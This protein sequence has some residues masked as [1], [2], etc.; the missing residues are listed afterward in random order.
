MSQVSAAVSTDDKARG[1]FAPLAIPT[2]ILW[3]RALGACLLFSLSGLSLVASPAL[4]AGPSVFQQ[5]PPDPA[6]VDLAL[7]GFAVHCDG[8]GD[9]APALQAAIDAVAARPSRR[10]LVFVGPG[11][12]RL[13]ATV[14]VWRGVR[15][16][17][18][19]PQRPVF[20]LGPATPGFQGPDSGYLF[21]FAG[22]SPKDGQPVRDGGASGFF[23]A[24]TNCDIEIADGNPGA[25]GVRF[26]VAQHC[27]LS[28]IDFR[29]G[30]ARAGVERVGNFF[31]NLTFSGGEYGL[32]AHRTAPSWPFL[33]LDSTFTG[34][35][36]AA[37][38]TEEAGM[39]IVRGHFHDL[40]RAIEVEA[41]LPEQLW[42]KDSRFERITG[43]AITLS[44]TAN[45][46]SQGNLQNIVCHDVPTLLTL[47][48]T[49]ESTLAP[50]AARSY[51]VND[52]IHG[53]QSPG[54][55]GV[56]EVKTTA[57]LTPLSAPAAPPATDIPA[58]PP[59]AEWVDART[60]GVRGDGSTDD[61]AALQH[62]LQTHRVLYLP[63]GQYRVSDTLRLRPDGVLIGLHPATTQLALLPGAPAFAQDAGPRPVL[64]TARGGAAIV[65]GIGINTH[66]TPRVIGLDWQA[67]A[68]SL[69]DDVNFTSSHSTRGE[70]APFDWD[71][72][73][74]T[75]SP[76]LWVREGG[77][78]TF[79]GI[80]TANTQARSGLRIT[81]TR[82]SGRVYALSAE[83]HVLR[84]IE[85]E[86]A[87]HWS[88][89]GVQTESEGAEGPNDL[90]IE[91][92]DGRDLLFANTFLYRVSRTHTPF[93]NAIL[94]TLCDRVD[95][96]GLLVF[97]PTKYA[98][99]AAVHDT[100]TGRRENG[101]HWASL[102]V[103]AL[104]APA[105]KLP[106]FATLTTL[107]EG[108][109]SIDGL[110]PLP[111]GELAFI[112]V[113]RGQVFQW[114]PATGLR[115]RFESPVKPVALAQDPATHQLLV[116]DRDGQVFRVIEKPGATPEL[117]PLAQSPLA[118]VPPQTP[119]LLPTSLYLSE[120]FMLKTTFSAKV[121]RAD[122]VMLPVDVPVLGPEGRPLPWIRNSLWRA[123]GLKLARPG[124]DFFLSDAFRNKTYRFRVRADGGL[125]NP[126][127]F[128]EAGEADNVRDAAGNVF[129]A[130]GDVFVF[131][132]DGR[133]LARLP[134]PERALGLALGGPGQRTLYVAARHA[135]YAIHL[136][137]AFE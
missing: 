128:A 62:A 135:L 49:G 68:Q 23:S 15:I 50:A 111:G 72:G 40:P 8:R 121:W 84:E 61:T 101:R 105:R 129:L 133:Q 104:P 91:I 34:Q 5:R 130:A 123:H 48:E 47:R 103:N 89:F 119:A 116:I 131:A 13:G 82:A 110:L 14:N 86:R 26:H 112:D 64:A 115:L 55:G 45:S 107:A 100:T 33:L 53:W 67:G 9:D 108:F 51:V 94:T 88:F 43:P 39:T 137:N 27:F 60:L 6:A 36:S 99:D 57:S 87:A 79:L 46:R 76:S 19:G 32:I 80:W 78:G 77:G 114:S 117:Q 93:P 90:P 22:D 24:L 63:T 58:L 17:G 42:V 120:D 125:E 16:I 59:V 30:S 96:R 85:I 118:E 66:L 28:H 73:W 113:P 25:V 102:P 106:A 2:W 75:Q 29:L 37:I 136:A 124:E 38:I 92:R 56:V 134:L 132:P 97:S 70:P 98:Y 126:R 10:G 12:Y 127:L 1:L 74:D 44:D 65:S 54:P 20:L 71:A 7:P 69:C 11:T 3:R 21:R 31:R 81:D 41:G 122:S 83:H 52:L 4:V 18:Y 109:T 35:R 95:F